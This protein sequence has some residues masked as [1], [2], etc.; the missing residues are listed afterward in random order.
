MRIRKRVLALLLL[1]V[2]TTI[3]SVSTAFAFDLVCARKCNWEYSACANGCST[4]TGCYD[5]C[6]MD[7]ASC[8]DGCLAPENQVP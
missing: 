3:A 2:L 4:D 1:T 5:R 7:K 6:I 8:Y